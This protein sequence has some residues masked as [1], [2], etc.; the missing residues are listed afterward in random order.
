M[1]S[2]RG[3]LDHLER[4]WRPAPCRDPFHT[5]P[6]TQPGGP[7]LTFDYRQAIAPLCPG[8]DGTQPQCPTCGAFPYGVRIEAYDGYATRQGE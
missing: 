1:A 2:I 5:P 3:R 7:L 6:R 8:W 4:T